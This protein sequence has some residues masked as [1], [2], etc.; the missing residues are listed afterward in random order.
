MYRR[1]YFNAEQG[2]WIPPR[3]SAYRKH[4][5]NTDALLCLSPDV[6]TGFKLKNSAILLQIDFTKAFDKVRPDSL[7]HRLH[8]VGV[9]GAMLAWLSN[10]LADRHY[11][12]AKPSKTDYVA[13]ELGTPQGS[14]LSALLFTLY[15]APLL[16]LIT[17]HK[18]GFA[19]GIAIR[20]SSP[21]ASHSICVLSNQLILV[22]RF[23]DRYRLP[24]SAA[25]THFTLFTKR[26]VKPT[27][28]PPLYLNG[29]V[30]KHEPTPR[31]LGLTF[32]QKLICSR[33]IAD[34]KTANE[35]KVS[36]LKRSLGSSWRNSRDS[37]IM[38]DKTFV[39]PTH[40]MD[41]CRAL[42]PCED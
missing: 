27:E 22:Q 34:L 41:L 19:D 2:S 6:A 26:H 7:R 30:L 39:R 14:S 24:I 20:H 38:F 42:A 13:V 17:A 3:Q 28:L 32:D 35:R 37:L 40:H 23:R 1:L 5:S 25:K 31:F 9:R 12:V 21:N 33:H 4:H 29:T 36:Q 8:Q 10:F 18:L 16:D 11:R 15:T